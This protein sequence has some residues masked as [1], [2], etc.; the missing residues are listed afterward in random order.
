MNTQDINKIAKAAVVLAQKWQTRANELLT[1]EEKGIQ[2]Q[3]KRLAA[4]FGAAHNDDA[5]DGFNDGYGLTQGNNAQ[6]VADDL[7]GFDLVAAYDLD[8][9]PED[10]D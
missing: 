6:A 1:S 5:L 9:C 8:D 3:M 10:S 4:L 7:I 2:E